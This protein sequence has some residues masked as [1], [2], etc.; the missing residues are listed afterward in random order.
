MEQEQAVGGRY[1][2]CGLLGQ[3][4]MAEVHQARDLRLDR[5]VAVKVLRPELAADPSYRVRFG[6]EAR[7]AAG[8]NH[9]GIVA[10]FDSGEGAGWAMDL[11]YIV[12]EHLRG[13]T[14]AELL[15]GGP[16]PS[17]ERALRICGE[18]LDALAH[19]HSSGTVHRD[20]KPANVMVTDGGV[21]KVMDFGIA[22]PLD[23]AQG[24]TM[25]GTGM[26]LGTAEYLSPEQARGIPVDA[27][28]D[29]YS[30]GC[31]LYELLTSRPPFRAGTPLATV[32]QHLEEEPAPPSRY[33]PALPPAVDALLLTALAK[34]RE[35][36]FADARAMRAAVD[37]VLRE[38]RPPAGP[39]EATSPTGPI[40]ASVQVPV[41]PKRRLPRAALVL[42]GCSLLVVPA[43]V[44]LA[45]GQGSSAP[46][47]VPAPDLRGKS[48]AEA[49]RTLQ[50]AGL[51][52]GR[53]A[54]GDCAIPVAAGRAV[55]GQQP[56]PGADVARGGAVVLRIPDAP[57]V[58]R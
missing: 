18:I 55:C 39:A 54:T 52:V 37:R 1:L 29:L 22:R 36:R 27:R 49:R 4:G 35:H 45:S 46:T 40:T 9:P 11:P 30:T 8:L 10:V 26:V 53:I 13:Q 2:L 16:A 3:G 12:M 23:H 7:S 14:L 20:I 38:L 19:A 57:S 34:D 42:L 50:G 51:R 56:A 41:R 21:V 5:V 33:A 28:T 31:L 6:R 32:W 48:V 43:G 25:T 47:T 24:V 15:Q 58:T 44:Y 17:P